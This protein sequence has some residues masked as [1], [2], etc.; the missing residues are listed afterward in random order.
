MSRSNP[1]ESLVNPSSRWFE[2]Q[3]ENGEVR[4]YDKEQKKNV[5]VGSDFTFL[6]LDRLGKVGGWHD[7]SDSA[8]YSNEVK[9]TRKDVLVVRSFKEGTLAEGIYSAI[10][11]RVNAMGGSFIASCYIAYKTDSG[12]LAIGNIGFKGAALHAWSEFERAHR[13]ALYKQAIRIT[14]FTE[15]KK[16]RITFRVPT[17]TLVDT[18]PATDAAATALDRELQTFLKAYLAKNTKAQVEANAQAEPV[19]PH[20]S[21]EAMADDAVPSEP[22]DFAAVITDDDIPF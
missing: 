1:S 7:A 17:F 14:G 4:Y 13:A 20:L 10:K 19:A 3:G 8:I 21:D 22:P 5:V 9:D 2:W 6:L 16:G 12:V 11:D 15:G 18:T